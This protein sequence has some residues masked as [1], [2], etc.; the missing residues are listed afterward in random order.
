MDNEKKIFTIDLEFTFG[1]TQLICNN[2][3]TLS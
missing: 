1:Q 3:Q 2:F